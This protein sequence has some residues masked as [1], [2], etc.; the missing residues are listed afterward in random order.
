MAYHT[1]TLLWTIMCEPTSPITSRVPAY[2]LKGDTPLSLIRF[3]LRLGVSL[4][5]CDAFVYLTS[6]PYL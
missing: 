3:A 4:L 2:V 1:R 6:V 5:Y